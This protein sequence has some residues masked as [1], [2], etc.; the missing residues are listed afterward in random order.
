MDK[1]ANY[2][3]RPLQWGQTKLLKSEYELTS[4]DLVVATLRFRSLW[5]T[6]ATA[7]SADGCWT[8]KRMGFWQTRATIRPCDSEEEIATFR[9]NTWKE[10][11]TL[12]LPDGR[13]YLANTN[14]W[15]TQYAF[16]DEAGDPLI[17]Y[18]NHGVFRSSAEVTI[19]PQAAELPELPWMVMLGWYLIVM[20]QNDSAATA[21][22]AS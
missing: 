9:N 16:K 5:G 3:G 4:Q 6:F 2:V 22:A 8:F 11:G 14:F 18:R 21:A 17:H 19:S 20:M 10:G 1:I 15:Q 7:Q 13:E 12:V